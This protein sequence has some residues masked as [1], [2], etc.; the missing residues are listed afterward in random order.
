MTRGSL[1]IERR[2][3]SLRFQSSFSALSYQSVVLKMTVFSFAMP[4]DSMF[5]SIGFVGTSSL[6]FS[7][8]FSLQRPVLIEL[9]KSAAVFFFPGVCAIVKLNCNTFSK[10]EIPKMLNDNPTENKAYWLTFE[11]SYSRLLLDCIN[12]DYLVNPLS[13]GRKTLFCNLGCSQSYHCL[14]TVSQKSI[15][16]LAFIF[17]IEKHA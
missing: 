12:K 13:D 15:D 10:I 8:I 6:V 4:A 14:P 11:K 17:A 16:E 3:C 7:T 9:E 2:I 1:G 5:T